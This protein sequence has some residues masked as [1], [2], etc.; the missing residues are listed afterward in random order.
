MYVY[1]EL[2][3]LQIILA[4]KRRSL[5]LNKRSWP[6]MFQNAVRHFYDDK[7]EILEVDAQGSE[8]R[9]KI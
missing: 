5:N 1:N 9:P 6:S 3:H 2:E 4:V 7:N 8:R